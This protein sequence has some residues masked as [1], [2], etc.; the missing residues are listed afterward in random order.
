MPVFQAAWLYYLNNP[1]L[2]INGLALFYAL[3]GSWLVF[4]AQWRSVRGGVPLAAGLGSSLDTAEAG[5]DARVNRMFHRIGLGC[6]TL[7]LLLTLISTLV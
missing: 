3:S 7:G 4:A 2:V 6:L 5:R 1:A